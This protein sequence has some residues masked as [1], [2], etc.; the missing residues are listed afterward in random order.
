MQD[1]VGAGDCFVGTF[2]YLLNKLLAITSDLKH[3]SLDEIAR[4]A[5]MSC[6]ASSYSV[7]FKGGFEKYPNEI[8]ESWEENHA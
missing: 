1:T 8:I 5:R 3:I 4:I 6:N 2:A 7:Q